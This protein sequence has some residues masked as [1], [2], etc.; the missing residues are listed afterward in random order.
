MSI[1]E[2]RRPRAGPTGFALVMESDRELRAVIRTALQLDGHRVE[3]VADCAGVLAWRN[4]VGPVPDECWPWA[5]E[6]WTRTG[7]RYR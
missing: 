4:N 3:C 5:L 2:K 6:S 1:I 7:R